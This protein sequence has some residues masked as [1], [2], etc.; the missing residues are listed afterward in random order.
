MALDN[1]LCSF[2]LHIFVSVI[3]EKIY[4]RLFISNQIQALHKPLHTGI[5]QIEQK[6]NLEGHMFIELILKS[7][8]P[9]S[10]PP[11]INTREK[12]GIQR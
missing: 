2:P 1:V 8:K 3:I 10:P 9:L 11:H 7:N 5:T 12:K 6:K 4:W